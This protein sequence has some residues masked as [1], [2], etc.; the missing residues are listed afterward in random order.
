MQPSYNPPYNKRTLDEEEERNLGVALAQALP[1]LPPQFLGLGDRGDGLER[2][3]PAAQLFRAVLD[4]A[5]L[6]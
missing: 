3:R 5:E 6:L 2:S 4:R 1:Q